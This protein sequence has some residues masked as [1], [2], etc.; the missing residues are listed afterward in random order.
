[1]VASR[2]PQEAFQKRQVVNVVHAVSRLGLFHL[3][4]QTGDHLWTT[5]QVEQGIGQ[6]LW[7]VTE[8][9]STSALIHSPWTSDGWMQTAV[10]VSVDRFDEDTAIPALWTMR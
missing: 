6:S 3:V 2:L 7:T 4:P 10:P 5:A 8:H 9:A 1:M